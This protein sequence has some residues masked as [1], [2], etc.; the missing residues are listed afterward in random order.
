MNISKPKRAV[1][2]A[3]IVAALTLVCSSACEP[4]SDSVTTSINASI[5]ETNDRVKV[6]IGDINRTPEGYTQQR[7]KYIKEI[8]TADEN[9][10]MQAVIGLDDYYAVDAVDS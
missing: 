4:V 5:E 6:F 8:A 10:I 9:K 2:C 1:V 3:A 7:S